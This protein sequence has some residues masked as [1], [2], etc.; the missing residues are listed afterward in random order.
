MW[1][2][3]SSLKLFIIL[4]NLVVRAVEASTS[5]YCVSLGWQGY[6]DEWVMASALEEPAVSWVQE[7]D[8]EKWY[9]SV[10]YAERCAQ[11]PTKTPG[12]ERPAALE[13]QVEAEKR[14]WDMSSGNKAWTLGSLQQE[15]G[16]WEWGEREFSLE[17]DGQADGPFLAR[18]W[19]LVE[20]YCGT[21]SAQDVK[22]SFQE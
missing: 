2:F 1:T 7:T 9:L 12:R 18:W 16:R 19:L 8:G 13:S 3:H 10:S 17:V 11:H 5:S 14:T 21:S 22:Y 4:G 20:E 6:E 15:E